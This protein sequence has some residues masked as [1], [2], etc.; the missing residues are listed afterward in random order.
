MLFLHALITHNFLQYA[1]LGGILASIAC[2]MIG[3]LVVA[4]RMS[5][6]AGG[7]AHTTLAGMGIA[8]FMQQ[9]PLYGA[10]V[11]AIIAGLIIGIISLKVEKYA[12]TIISI[13]WAIGMGVGL[14][15]ISKTP[16]YNADL[17][18]YLFGNILLI[19]KNN[20]YLLLGLDVV[21][22]VLITIFYRQLIA[23]TFDEEF[24]RVRG[25]KVDFYYLMLIMLI[26]LTVVSLIQ[27]VGLI[28]I[29]ALLT[30]PAVIGGAFFKSLGKIIVSSVILGGVFTFLGLWISY[31]FNLPSGAVIV[32]V[33]TGVTILIPLR[34][35]F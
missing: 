30:A 35:L 21:I 10:L 25:L 31:V 23:V 24:A 5:Y 16:G 18:S 15:F 33:A 20:L 27:V 4:K 8:Y 14:I 1:V 32:L 19:S 9:S 22:V 26:A 2:G 29:L 17:M 12:D 34:A 6:I 13:L 11:V 7:I 3:P 28:L